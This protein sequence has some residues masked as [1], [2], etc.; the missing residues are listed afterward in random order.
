[1]KPLPMV[2]LSEEALREKEAKYCSFGDTVHYSPVP[3]FFKNCEGSFLYDREDKP[4]LDLQMW[5]SAVNF[6]YRNQTIIDALKAQLDRLPQLACQYL[7]EEKV[8]VSEKLALECLRAFGQEGRIQFNVGGAQAIEDSMKLVRNA[9]GKSQFMAFTGGYHGRTLGASEITSSYRYRRRFGHFSNR[10]HFVPFPYC[11]RCPYGKTLD[12]CDYYCVNQVERLFETEYNSFW[13]TK[14]NE[15]EFVAFYIEPVQATGG[16]IIPP[17][18]YFSRLQKI[19]KERKILLVDDEIQ[20]GFFR[21]GKF[22]ALE[23][24]GVQPDIVVFGKAMTNG[25]NP[26]SGVWAKEAL[27][28][29]EKFPP[30]STHSTFSSNPLGTAA[31][32]ATLLWI[33]QQHYEKKVMESGAYFLRQIEILKTR[34]KTIGDVSGLGLALRIEVTKPDRF[35]P[36]RILADRIF[37]AGLTGGIPSSRGPMG[38]VLDIGGHYKNVFTLAPALDIT[39]DEIDLGIELL[40]YLFTSCMDSK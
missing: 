26:I 25:L 7:H 12:S 24:F 40:D 27:I 34:H 17:P 2:H 35:T 10:A 31:T 4:Y 8:L 1:M 32:L 38:L 14:A 20:M 16:Y 9:T 22:W 6:G 30:G 15:A 28:S 5:Y 18:E 19:L 36:D 21:T 29:P 33:E 11:Y 39:T 37:E 23:H 3:K 13:D